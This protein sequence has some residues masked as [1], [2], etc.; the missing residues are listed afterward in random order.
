VQEI[1]CVLNLKMLEK[2]E[3]RFF[4]SNK[5]FA[6]IIRERK[7]YMKKI[8]VLFLS[9]IFIGSFITGCT[10]TIYDPDS[11]TE[12]VKIETCENQT[13]VYHSIEYSVEN[14]YVSPEGDLFRVLIEYEKKTDFDLVGYGYYSGKDIGM[15]AYWSSVVYREKGYPN[16]DLVKEKLQNIQ[17]IV[18]HTNNEIARLYDQNLYRENPTKAIENILWVNAFVI[19]EFAECAGNFS[20]EVNLFYVIKNDRMRLEN[21]TTSIH[22]LMH[23]IGHYGW[24]DADGD[25]SDPR[26]W[27]NLS[28]E[29]IMRKVYDIWLASLEGNSLL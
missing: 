1:T 19:S 23:P 6:V 22:E 12:D 3:R 2:K 29:S 16:A 26:L 11:E 8:V 17:V 28:D 10:N 15:L 21:I 25:H 7:I 9:S 27:I 13:P 5:N 14:A 24:G 18:T 20:P 4:Y